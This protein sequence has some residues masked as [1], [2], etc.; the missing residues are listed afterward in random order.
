MALAT[1]RQPAS[2]VSTAALG[3]HAISAADPPRLCRTGTRGHAPVRALSTTGCSAWPTRR[4]GLPTGTGASL[5]HLSWGADTC[6]ERSTRDDGS[7]VWPA[8][9]PPE[10]AR[11][12]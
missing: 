2:S 8:H 11:D 6:G 4:P 7:A 9:S 12:L 5:A 1:P 10:P 3:W